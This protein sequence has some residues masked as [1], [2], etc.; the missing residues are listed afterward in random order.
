M[1]PARGSALTTLCIALAAIALPVSSLPGIASVAQ[2]EPLL[3]DGQ[4]V[5]W[6]AE[7][8]P[9]PIANTDLSWRR[10]AAEWT[11]GSAAF[12]PVDDSTPGDS[13]PVQPDG[14]VAFAEWDTARWAADVGDPAL[15]GFT[16]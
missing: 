6:P 9:L 11:A 10:A 5:T 14:V 8:W 2:A 3:I 12:A 1:N 15:I 13:V 4:V 7:A 16:L